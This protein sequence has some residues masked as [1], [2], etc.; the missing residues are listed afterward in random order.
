MKHIV[1][2]A[3]G[4]GSNAKKIIDHFKD[5]PEIAVAGIISN[6]AE[7][8]VLELARSHNLPSLVISKNT[9]NEGS[10]LI[11]W[12][13]KL[14]TKLIVLAGFLW[15]IPDYLIKAY[16]NQIINIHPALLPAYGG[17]GMYGHHV[18]K[19]VFKNKEQYSGITIHY[20]NEHFDE[21]AHIFQASCKVSDVS[22]PQEIASRVLELE[23]FHYPREIEKLLS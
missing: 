21:G 7:A 4:R 14:E 6:K 17:K 8:G 10:V 11:P 19:A 15:L 3:S 13:A 16:P 20:V 22:S 23:H 1:I 2:F 12:L 18:H 9:F 5:H